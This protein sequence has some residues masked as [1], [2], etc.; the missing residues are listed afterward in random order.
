MSLAEV[1]EGLGRSVEA[2]EVLERLLARPNRFADPDMQLA[3]ARLALT[4]GRID[5]AERAFSAAIDESPNG[6]VPGH[7][8]VS[9]H[10]GLGEIAL[11]HRD[12]PRTAVEHLLAA[13]AVEPNWSTKMFGLPLRLARLL[14][15]AG[16]V[17]AVERFCEKVLANM[18]DPH[19]AT[20]E[21][22]E[23]ARSRSREAL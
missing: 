1:L 20:A 3:R 4:L 2:I 10:L 8:A 5:D 19:A 17:A 14:L 21:L 9:G 13:A 23:E 11:V 6:H 12:Q 15:A 18:T 7:G 16:E 22:L